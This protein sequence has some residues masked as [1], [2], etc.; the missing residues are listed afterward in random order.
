[1]ATLLA[2][3]YAFTV[4]PVYRATAVLA[5]AS[6]GGG[7]NG[8][9][10]STL[11]QLGGMA[12]LAGLAGGS[13][14][15]QA[16][17][18]LAVLRSR[19]FTERFIRERNL[20]PALF[21]KLW[22]ANAKAW[23]V[24]EERQPSYSRANK[25]FAEKVRHVFQDKKTGL[26]NLQID[27]TDRWEAADWANDLVHRLNA[28]MRSRALRKTEASV[29][30]LQKELNGTIEIGTREAINRLIEAQI[31]QRML[32][33]VTDEYSFKVIDAALPPDRIDYIFPNR[34]VLVLVGAVAGLMLGIA[35]L[36]LRNWVVF[37]RVRP[38]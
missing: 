35:L 30:F 25:Y 26:T 19:E 20:L 22:D 3:A 6:A 10:S 16:E 12:S 18:A 38:S 5:S 29:G 36:S 4:K 9:L 33:N 15:A 37:L 8:L 14:D 1:M 34:S 23:L 13:T 31:K 2:G 24:P 28:E 32:I 11:S 21:P 27:W 7:S 17:E